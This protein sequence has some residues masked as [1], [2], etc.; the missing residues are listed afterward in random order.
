MI[1]KFSLGITHVRDLSNV[2]QMNAQA[3]PQALRG[4][5]KYD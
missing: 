1:F 4:L 5:G 3:I 2:T